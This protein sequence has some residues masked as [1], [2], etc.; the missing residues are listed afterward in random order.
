LIFVNE[1]VEEQHYRELS[2]EWRKVDEKLNMAYTL[3]RARKNRG[4][5]ESL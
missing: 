3:E 2:G 1:L 5:K 4:K